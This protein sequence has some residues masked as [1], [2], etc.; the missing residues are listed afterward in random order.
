MQQQRYTHQGFKDDYKSKTHTFVTMNWIT[1]PYNKDDEARVKV[2]L[3]LLFN[4]RC[5]VL[6]DFYHEIKVLVRIRRIIIK[7]FELEDQNCQAILR[8]FWHKLKCSLDSFVVLENISFQSSQSGCQL[9]IVI[10]H[11]FF[12]NFSFSILQKLHINTSKSV[13]YL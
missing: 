4:M 8:S 13:N 12:K 1:Q 2:Q 3:M 7:L 11:L 9:L 6:D 10:F 5:N